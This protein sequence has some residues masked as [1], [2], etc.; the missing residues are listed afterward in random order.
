M[1]RE[2]RPSSL[3]DSELTHVLYFAHERGVLH[4]FSTRSVECSG[5]RIDFDYSWEM[6]ILYGTVLNNTTYT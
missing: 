1:W 3:G 2:N 5:G 6:C 4:A